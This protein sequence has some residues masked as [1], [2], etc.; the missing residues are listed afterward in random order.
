MCIEGDDDIIETMTLIIKKL[1]HSATCVKN[2]D[3]ALIILQKKSVEI[4]LIIIDV[5]L[6]R[7]DGPDLIK[8]IWK[9]DLQ[10][11]AFPIIIWSADVWASH[12]RRYQSLIAQL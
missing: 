11:Q 9:K 1:G 8:L 4:E 12:L 7:M 2:G 10:P 5:S 6:P 3:D